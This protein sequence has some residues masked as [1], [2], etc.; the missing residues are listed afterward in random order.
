MTS[1][2]VKRMETG[3]N[4]SIARV[5]VAGLPPIV[6]SREF[7]DY[8]GDGRGAAPRQLAGAS[9]LRPRRCSRARS[10]GDRSLSGAGFQ[11]R[12]LSLLLE[13]PGLRRPRRMGVLPPARSAHDDAPA[14]HRLSRQ[15]RARRPRRGRAARAA[16][17]TRAAWITG[18]GSSA[19]ATQRRSP[20]FSRCAGFPD[21]PR[22]PRRRHSP[23]CW[24]KNRAIS[25]KTS[26]VSGAKASKLYWACDMPS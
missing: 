3:R 17:A 10:A 14:R 16:V 24:S 25:V 12:G 20:T 4:R 1:M 19:R 6:S 11:R 8:A 15:Y 26:L 9:R 22:P 23:R 5:E 7:A 2:F 21:D 18:A 13:L